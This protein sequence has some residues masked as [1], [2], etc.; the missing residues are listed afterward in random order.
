MDL[1][2]F[3]YVAISQSGCMDL[4]QFGYMAISQFGYISV[5]IYGSIDLSQFGCMD[6]SQFGS[7][8]LSQFGSVDLSQFGPGLCEGQA[9]S[10]ASPALSWG[11]PVPA[12]PGRGLGDPELSLAQQRALG[13]SGV[14]G[15][16][17]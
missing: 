6:L 10:L 16:M 5:W 1:S 8:D 12:L 13:A 4:S 14:L 15:L 2:Q 3:G 17:N 9:L 7:M 11:C